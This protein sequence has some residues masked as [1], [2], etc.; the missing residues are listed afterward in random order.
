MC[1]IYKS[2]G[3]KFGFFDFVLSL[4]FAVGYLLC[5][6]PS[7]NN[8]GRLGFQITS[9]LFLSACL[10]IAGFFIKNSLKFL[11]IA[12]SLFMVSIT[13]V[14]IYAEIAAQ[15]EHK[16]DFSS[17]I[18]AFYYDK[19][20]AVALVWVSAFF[21]LTFFRLF[22]PANL[23]DPMIKEDYKKFVRRSSKGF[24]FFYGCFLFYGFFL[25]RAPWNSAGFNLIPFNSI[26]FYLTG[27]VGRYEG[28]IYLFGNVFCLMPI[29]FYLKIFKPET[30]FGRIVWLP[31]MI[32]GLLEI[33]QLI[34]K[35][36][37]C[38]I[39]DIILNS[40]GF[41]IG[42]FIIFLCDVLI[43]RITGGKEQTIF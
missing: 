4:V 31:V 5:V 39:D 19:P 7:F 33:S 34:F 37:D 16:G 22:L 21:M 40:L 20:L 35:T 9:A 12:L 26:Q 8:I 14:G 36:G 28:L 25:I 24:L 23:S 1:K 41:Y 32:S 42:A 15:L 6:I 29:G 27:Q 30:K 17:R 18:E 13:S 43:K 11:G 2:S 3:G 10:T 38:D